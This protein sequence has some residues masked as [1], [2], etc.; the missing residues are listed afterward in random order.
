MIPLLDA[1]EDLVKQSVGQAHHGRQA[2]DDGEDQGRTPITLGHS[3]FHR[4][5]LLLTVES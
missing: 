3:R 1:A 2:Y 4:R 5:L